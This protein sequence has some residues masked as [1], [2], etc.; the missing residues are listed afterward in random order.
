MEKVYSVVVITTMDG[1]TD[2]TVLGIYRNRE[3]AKKMA[4]EDRN[5]ELES[6]DIVPDDRPAKWN[7]NCITLWDND[8]DNTWW[9][10]EEHE[11]KGK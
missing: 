2:V 10:M 1:E 9:I 4:E 7:N 3:H 6:L 8:S 5:S 11:I